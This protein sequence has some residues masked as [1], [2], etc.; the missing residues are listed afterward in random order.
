MQYQT[1][2]RTGHASSRVIFGAAALGDVSQETADSVLGLLLEQGI[3]HI[4]TARSYGEAEVRIGPWMRY[5]RAS[6][7]LASKTG[8]RTR[9]AAIDRKSVV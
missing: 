1:F 7:F 9:D 2:G 6:F 8:A 4:D 5:H 3:N